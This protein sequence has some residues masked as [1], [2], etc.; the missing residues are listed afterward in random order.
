MNTCGLDVIAAGRVVPACR[1]CGMPMIE[2]G[3]APFAFSSLPYSDKS[4]RGALCCESC[5][6]WFHCCC[7]DT[8]TWRARCPVCGK[9]ARS[10]HYFCPRCNR[11]A[12]PKGEWPQLICV[13]C[14]GPIEL[15]ALKT[16]GMMELLVLVVVAVL[17]GG[18]AIG[19]LTH[20][21]PLPLRILM[22]ALALVFTAPWLAILVASVVTGMLGVDEPAAMMKLPL[23]EV[24]RF[25]D[26]PALLRYWRVYL[27]FINQA[28]WAVAV[29]VLI[30]AALAAPAIMR[31]TLKNK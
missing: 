3:Q 16:A 18:A 26:A 27:H 7:S 12:Q 14:S 2:D 9:P 30:L 25:A 15:T 4:N 20:S 13:H 23:R 29:T 19:V 11:A 21:S 22:S 31:E 8:S 5:N 1:Q 28:L 24:R 6:S 17:I 10:S